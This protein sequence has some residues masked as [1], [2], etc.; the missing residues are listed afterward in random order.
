MD[1]IRASLKRL[2]RS[3]DRWESEGGIFGSTFGRKVEDEGCRE[4][5]KALDD[6]EMEVRERLGASDA[7]PELRS[8]VDESLEQLEALVRC[9]EQRE[10]IAEKFSGQEGA[11]ERIDRL[12][13]REVEIRL[14]VR[15]QWDAGKPTEELDEEDPVA[16]IERD[17]GNQGE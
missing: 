3:E 13:K 11:Q 17:G 14:H 16:A 12:D 6:I 7:D 15:R 1:E 8:R 10:A 4:A 5:L 9:R 2:D